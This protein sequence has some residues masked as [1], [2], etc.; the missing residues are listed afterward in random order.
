MSRERALKSTP[1]NRWEEFAQ[2]DAE[3]YICTD[4][5]SHDSFEF[6]KSGVRIASEEFQPIIQKSGIQHQVVAELGCGIGRLLIPTSKYFKRAFGIDVSP[7]M[8][9]LANQNA[10]EREAH[11]VHCVAVF[12]PDEIAT[13]LPDLLGEVD[14][15]Y[16]YLVFQHIEDFEVI[17]SYVHSV[18]RLLSPK[19]IAYL[20]F[21]TRTKDLMYRFRNSMP[22]GLLP[23]FW[24]KAIRRIRREPGEIE[25]LFKEADLK[26]VGQVTP[27]TELHRYVV[28]KGAKSV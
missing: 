23:W 21:D 27:R 17:R 3:R 28:A 1:V 13:D 15:L 4:R 20:Q 26:M 14:F 8:A 16:S 12:K 7:E 11:N 24:R 25:N 10:I 19:G 6:W 18:S 22:D 2:H 9:R 5:I